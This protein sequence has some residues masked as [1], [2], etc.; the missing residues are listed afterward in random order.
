MPVPLRQE[1]QHDDY[2]YEEEDAAT[3]SV[4]ILKGIRQNLR[5]K[6]ENG[7]QLNNQ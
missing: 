7:N 6:F 3:T 2:G 5:D 4:D 1:G